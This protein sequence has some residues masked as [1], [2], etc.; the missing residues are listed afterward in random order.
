LEIL[1]ENKCVTEEAMFDY[2][3]SKDSFFIEEGKNLLI[4]EFGKEYGIYFSILE[5]IAS[6]K[7]SRTEIE[8]I[9]NMSIGG[10]LKRLEDEYDIVRKVRSVGAKK[11]SRNQKYQI[12]DHFFR[13]WFGLIYKNISH[14]ENERFLYVRK[15]VTRDLSSFSGVTLER[16]F[17]DIFSQSPDYST[18]GTYWEKGNQNEIDLIAV[19]NLNKT[20]EIAEITLNKDKI[21]LEKLKVKSIRL[22]TR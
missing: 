3:F 13:F 1:L 20:I 22:L 2:I 14:I 15:I 16:L 21:S 9:L 19:D 6:G 4:Q 7:T 18:F 12:K 11:D 10:H 8:S 17:I 5:L